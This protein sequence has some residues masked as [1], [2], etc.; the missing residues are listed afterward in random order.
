MEGDLMPRTPRTH[1]DNAYYHVLAR[2]NNKQ[3]IF[4]KDAD[5]RL[6]LSLL[7]KYSSRH[8]VT[9]HAYALLPNHIHLLVQI[10]T[11]PLSRLMHVLQQTYTQA[12]N[13]EYKRVGH[14]FQGRYKAMLVQDD[15]YLLALVRYIHMNPVEAGL[16][17]APSDYRWSSHRHYM[18][19]QGVGRV[20]TGFVKSVMGEYGTREIDGYFLLPQKPPRT[21]TVDL[22]LP[23]PACPKPAHPK[24]S[25]PESVPFDELLRAVVAVTGI[26]P[27]AITGPGKERSIVRARRLFAYYA[28]YLGGHTM[29]EIAS[30]LHKSN[31]LISIAASDVSR[32]IQKGDRAWAAEVQA[33]DALLTRDSGII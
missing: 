4:R 1:A 15:A 26:A 17:K 30:Y 5:Y 13:R 12:H 6:Y 22:T 16:C 11:E 20:E 28:A 29:V 23:Q 32:K 8:C 31:S 9:V 24:A 7:D 2:G 27:A 18:R 25:A 21:E 19:G 3:D 10:G 14:L 33:V